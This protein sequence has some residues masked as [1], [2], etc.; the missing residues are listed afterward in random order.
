LPSIPRTAGWQRVLDTNEPDLPE[1]APV[2][3]AA[4]RHELPGRSLAAFVAIRAEA[5]TVEAA[6]L[7]SAES[8][9]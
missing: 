9:R 1:D 3:P 4:A 5:S 8:S 6:D 7:P 2:E